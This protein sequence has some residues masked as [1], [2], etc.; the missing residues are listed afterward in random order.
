SARFGRTQD[1]GYFQRPEPGCRAADIAN[2]ANGNEQRRGGRRPAARFPRALRRS[3]RRGDPRR[4]ARYA[5]P[6]GGSAEWLD[7]YTQA[8]AS[9]RVL[10]FAGDH[11]RHLAAAAK[12]ALA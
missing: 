3:A 4:Q 2:T 9:H 11:D 6:A 10:R 12:C 7:R 5:G 1:I 8:G